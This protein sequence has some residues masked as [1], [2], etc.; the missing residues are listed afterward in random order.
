MR[1]CP[2]RTYVGPNTDLGET[3]GHVLPSPLFSPQDNSESGTEYSSLIGQLP[4]CWALIG[5][6]GRA[7][8]ATRAGLGLQ[9]GEANFGPAEK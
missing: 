3:L 4:S 1:T 6:E 5:Q 7:G 9:L 2:A 8:R